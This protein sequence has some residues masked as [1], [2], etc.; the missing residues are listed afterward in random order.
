MMH[1]STFL[2]LNAVGSEGTVDT[3]VSPGASCLLRRVDSVLNCSILSSVT[4]QTFHGLWQVVGVSY[5]SD[6][7]LFHTHFILS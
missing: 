3:H 4:I 2:C 1:F 5:Y 7:F 6:D